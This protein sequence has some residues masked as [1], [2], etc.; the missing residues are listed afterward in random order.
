MDRT[1]WFPGRL[2]GGIALVAGPLLWLAG[3]SVRHLSL[4][5]PFTAEQLRYFDSLPFA[6]TWQLAAY[7]ENPALVTAGFAL[8][9]AGSAVLC[10]AFATLA[11]I[12]GH[13]LAAWGGAMLIATLFSRLYW[14]GVEQTAFQLIGPLG[15]ERATELVL[16]RY[17]EISYGPWLLAVALSFGQYVGTILLCVGGYLTGTF[18]TARLAL[19][20][21][22]GTLW[23]GV[24]KAA[25]GQDLVAIG[26]L[27]AVL[28]P[29]GVTVLRTGI[30]ES[31]RRTRRLVSW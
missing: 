1:A 25:H 4:R 29:L 11:R 15:L 30:P 13:G 28:V 20:L 5:L 9:A 10:L 16:G 8:F 21:F 22:A 3:L 12:V 14:T 27:C 24:L 19:L 26:G 17:T 2:L 6:A 31:A 23:T 18:G 7:A